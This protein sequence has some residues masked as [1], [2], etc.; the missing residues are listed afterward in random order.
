MEK[1]ENL[2]ATNEEVTLEIKIIILSKQ[3]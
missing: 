2:T 1:M 3:A